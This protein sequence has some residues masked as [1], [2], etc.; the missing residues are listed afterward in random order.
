MKEHTNIQQATTEA[1]RYHR[2]KNAAA[3]MM[4]GATTEAEKRQWRKAKNMAARR[5]AA[6]ERWIKAASVTIIA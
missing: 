3:A 4:R 1:N 2:L 5:Q 6:A